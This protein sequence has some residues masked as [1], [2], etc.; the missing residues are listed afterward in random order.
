MALKFTNKH[1]A[2]YWATDTERADLP[3][4]HVYPT[5]CV[6]GQWTAEA[7]GVTAYE[8]SRKRAVQQFIYNWDN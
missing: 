5:D 6:S 2:G 8:F 1:D 4:I 3:E 7:N